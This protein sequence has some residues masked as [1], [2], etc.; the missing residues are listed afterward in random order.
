MSPVDPVIHKTN[1]C[2]H[3]PKVSLILLDWS[4]RERY[5][6]LD[7]LRKQTVPREVYELIWIELYD[8]VAGEALEKAEV[9]IS[10]GQK[11]IYHKHMGYNAGLLMA[12]GEIV[13]V[14]DSDAVFPR[15][16]IESIIRGFHME[17]G[18]EPKSQVLMHYQWRTSSTYPD[19]LRDLSQLSD[20]KWAELWP[21]V[22][23]C[24]TVRKVD[25]MRF[26]GFDEHH[27]FRGYMCGPYDL[28]WRLVNA[29]IPEVWH[30][31]EVAL[32]HF[33]HPDP[34]ATYAQRFSFDLWREIR[35]I[36][37][38]GHALTAVEALCS[39]RILPLNENPRIYRSR[40]SMRRIGTA[41]E[42]GYASAAAPSGFSIGQKLR[43][44]IL[45]ALE[46]LI[47]VLP[48]LR[49][50]KLLRWCFG[51]GSRRL[52]EEL[53][54]SCRHAEQDESAA[55]GAKTKQ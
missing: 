15:S 44:R 48:E 23:A 22:G 11:G 19:D 50:L 31:P 25:A 20:Y 3:P 30:D 17:S 43:L 33:S 38:D 52:M 47:R 26:G 8:R 53:R 40:M 41:F 14:C 12:Q 27:S 45:L 39:G 29:G 28:G 54:N 4:V 5:Q 37:L 46:P 34:Y 32:W 7:W 18:S 35:H 1:N 55:P 49:L 16:F 36:H 2:L 10:C 24:M 21:N 13:T 42:A 6:A 9:V 51:S